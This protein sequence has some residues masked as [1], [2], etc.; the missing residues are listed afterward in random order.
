MSLLTRNVKGTKTMAERTLYILGI[1]R[2]YITNKTNVTRL[3]EIVE[4]ELG[5]SDLFISYQKDEEDESHNTIP[6]RSHKVKK[7]CQDAYRNR[8]LV[9]VGFEIFDETDVFS[10]QQDILGGRD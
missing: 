7:L 5:D 8:I 10:I 3:W 2:K 6:A 1:N 4:R 9:H